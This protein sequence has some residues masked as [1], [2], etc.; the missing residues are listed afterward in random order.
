MTE[1]ITTD[2]NITLIILLSINDPSLTAS[3]CFLVPSNLMPSNLMPSNLIPSDRR[4]I[5]E[6]KKILVIPEN[7]D[8]ILVMDEEFKILSKG[9]AFSSLSSY[10]WVLSP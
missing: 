3:S 1:I 9:E 10:L 7:A 2:R 6:T 4:Y 5:P 8:S